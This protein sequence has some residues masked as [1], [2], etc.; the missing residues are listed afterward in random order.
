M[1]RSQIRTVAASIPAVL[2]ARVAVFGWPRVARAGL[3]ERT[4]EAV[5]KAVGLV[6]VFPLAGSRLKSQHDRK[7]PDDRHH[8]A[9]T[10]SPHRN[11][12]YGWLRVLSG[13]A[14]GDCTRRD[15]INI[16]CS[17]T[18]Y[19]DSGPGAAGR[20]SPAS[21]TAGVGAPGR[22]G[23]TTRRCPAAGCMPHALAARQETWIRREPE[24]TM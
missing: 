19:D 6:P 16:P 20:S 24:R 1:P 7:I 3:I 8:V 2:T 12:K 14:L 5:P 22:G 15:G 9:L 23:W 10:N 11:E 13:N 17:L 18:L 21:M 4:A